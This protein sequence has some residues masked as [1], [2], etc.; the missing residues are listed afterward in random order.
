MYATDKATEKDKASK[1]VVKKSLQR[2]LERF[3]IGLGLSSASPAS[4]RTYSIS[5]YPLLLFSNRHV[6]KDP[7]HFNKLS[8]HRIV[9]RGKRKIVTWTVI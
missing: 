7:P 2:E 5:T 3:R 4:I 8:A 6:S 9:S 1:S